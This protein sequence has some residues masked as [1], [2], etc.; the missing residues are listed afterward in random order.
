MESIS[1]IPF[2][3]VSGILPDNPLIVPCGEKP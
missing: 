2:G 1:E 3:V